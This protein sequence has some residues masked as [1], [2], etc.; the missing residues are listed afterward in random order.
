[1]YRIKLTELLFEAF[2]ADVKMIQQL[3][4]RINPN[5]DLGTSGDNRDGVDGDFGTRTKNAILTVI[6]D[7]YQDVIDS[8]GAPK[9]NN[10][11]IN[12]ESKSS[13]IKLKNL[14]S[15]NYIKTSLKEAVDNI[16]IQIQRILKDIDP[17]ID[18]GTG[19]TGD[20]AGTGIDGVWGTKT[21]KAIN[22]CFEYKL[23]S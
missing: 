19:G 21:K 6:S 11:E 18:L 13:R 12:T 10:S 23:L 7:I 9:S 20:D 1:M 8:G 16:V 14:I 17:N 5:I 15:D 2:D 4:K 22:L 3:L